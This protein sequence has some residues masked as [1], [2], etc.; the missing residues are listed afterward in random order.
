M[1]KKLDDYVIIYYVIAIFDIPVECIFFTNIDNSAAIL[2]LRRE[3]TRDRQA[4]NF[5][6]KNHI[7]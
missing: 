5:M 6:S 4:L 7:S 2:T 1:L 3:T